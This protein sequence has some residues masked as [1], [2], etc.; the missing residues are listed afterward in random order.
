MATLSESDAELL[1]FV[2]QKIADAHFLETTD[3]LIEVIKDDLDAGATYLQ[4]PGTRETLRTML[5]EK[6][7]QIRQRMAKES[8]SSPGDQGNKPEGNRSQHDASAKPKEE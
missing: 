8:S 1:E 2:R 7:D 4:Q 6:R 3:Y 5:A